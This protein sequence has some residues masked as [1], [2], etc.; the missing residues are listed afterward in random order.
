LYEIAQK[1]WESNKVVGGKEEK[2]RQAVLVNRRE[3][4]LRPGEKW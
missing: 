4:P 1:G 3:V 2:Q